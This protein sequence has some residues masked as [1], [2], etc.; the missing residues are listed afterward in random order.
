MLSNALRLNFSYLT[1][2]H[3]LLSRYHPKIIGDI[4]RNKQKSKREFIHEI[5][6][7]IIMKMKMKIDYIDTAK[8]DLSLNMVKDIINKKVS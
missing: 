5:M 6:R 2:I 7:L 3:I 4:L 1:I 8:I